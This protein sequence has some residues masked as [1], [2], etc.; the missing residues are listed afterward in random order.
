MKTNSITA[1]SMKEQSTTILADSIQSFKTTKI[2]NT[3]PT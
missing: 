2:E 3:F 1:L